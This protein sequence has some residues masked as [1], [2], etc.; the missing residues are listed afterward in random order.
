M[1]CH[2]FKVTFSVCMKGF[3]ITTLLCTTMIGTGQCTE[4]CYQHSSVD[5]VWSNNDDAMIN[6]GQGSQDCP[7][8]VQS[9]HPWPSQQQ[10]LGLCKPVI[11]LTFNISFQIASGT[12][13]YYLHFS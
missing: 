2:G 3:K 13:V 4:E 7:E 8:P 10:G 1:D 9:R 12:S 5:S 11:L 6:D